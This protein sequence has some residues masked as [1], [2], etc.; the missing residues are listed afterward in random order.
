[1]HI[2]TLLMILTF[3]FEL[4]SEENKIGPKDGLNS[5]IKNELEKGINSREEN[6]EWNSSKQK[7]LNELKEKCFLS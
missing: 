4:F 1:M 6:L 7:W 5:F 2:I 3:C